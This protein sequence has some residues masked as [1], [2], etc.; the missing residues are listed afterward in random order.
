MTAYVPAEPV[1]ADSTWG[2]SSPATCADPAE[3]VAYSNSV[4]KRG[5][6]VL[7]ELGGEIYI[8]FQSCDIDGSR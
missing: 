5:E 6:T 3:G 4:Y 2:S 7:L 1:T 8:P